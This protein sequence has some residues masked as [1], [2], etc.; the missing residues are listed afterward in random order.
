MAYY[1]SA[2]FT[3]KQSTSRHEEGFSKCARHDK[4]SLRT[5][6]PHACLMGLDGLVWCQSVSHA[7]AL[8]GRSGPY[9]NIGTKQF[10]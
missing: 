9:S 4:V 1:I 8:G 6:C 3:R 2:R 7:M 10:E 5:E